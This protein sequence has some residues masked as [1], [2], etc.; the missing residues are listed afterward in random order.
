MMMMMTT[1]MMI[2]II[3][4]WVQIRWFGGEGGDWIDIY[5]YIKEWRGDWVSVAGWVTSSPGIWTWMEEGT[6]S[7]GRFR[8]A[9]T[10]RHRTDTLQ[11]TPPHP[12]PQTY[13]SIGA[14]RLPD[15][16]HPPMLGTPMLT[17]VPRNST[18]KVPSPSVSQLLLLPPLPSPAVAAAAAAAVAALAVESAADGGASIIIGSAKRQEARI[19]TCWS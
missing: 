7:Y 8:H 14:D 5:I 6:W 12:D 2:I 9:H 16:L 17:P 19:H 13:Q 4:L 18:S 3:M 1:M 15:L 10:D 11:C